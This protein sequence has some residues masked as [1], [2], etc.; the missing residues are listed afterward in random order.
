MYIIFH[1]YSFYYVLCYASI[2]L[3]QYKCFNRSKLLITLPM[4]SK[5]LIE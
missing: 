1:M 4:S 2:G 3:S 5:N